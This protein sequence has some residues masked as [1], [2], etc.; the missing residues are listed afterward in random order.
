[1][2][3]NKL[4]RIILEQTKKYAPHEICGFV[5]FDGKQNQFI[6]CENQVEDK[7]NYFGISKIYFSQILQAVIFPNYFTKKAI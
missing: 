2:I 7:T 6:S 3:E 4:K 1:M 5:V